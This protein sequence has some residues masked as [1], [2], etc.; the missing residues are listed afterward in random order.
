M[1]GIRL[2]EKIDSIYQY[3]NFRMEQDKSQEAER[4]GDKIK[5]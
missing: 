2:F 5:D 3:D 4:G 1:K